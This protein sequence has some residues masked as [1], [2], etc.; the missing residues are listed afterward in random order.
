MLAGSSG[1]GKTTALLQCVREMQDR[2]PNWLGLYGERVAWISADR[3]D[4]LTREKSN[5][6]GIKCIEYYCLFEPAFYKN[7]TKLIN[8]VKHAPHKLFQH[9]VSQFKKPYDLLVVDT[10][11]AFITGDINNYNDAITTLFPMTCHAINHQCAVLNVHHAPKGGGGKDYYK[12]PQ[13]MILGSNAFQGYH[14]GLHVLI[15]QPKS[16]MVTLWSRAHD[17]PAKDLKLVRKGGWLSADPLDFPA[18]EDDTEVHSPV[19]RTEVM[20]WIRDN[21]SCSRETAYRKIK[22]ALGEE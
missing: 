11:G 6:I 17:G 21:A 22:V 14:D 15:D 20:E 16:S 8:L 1:A 3:P 5:E 18:G 12:R 19:S 4:Q 9:C 10:V 13:D 7:P 2:K